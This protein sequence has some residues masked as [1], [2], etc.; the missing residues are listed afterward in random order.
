ML[1]GAAPQDFRPHFR[2]TKALDGSHDPRTNSSSLPGERAEPDPCPR[3][4]PMH[5]HPTHALVAA[6]LLASGCAVHRLPVAVAPPVVVAGSVREVLPNDYLRVS[7]LPAGVTVTSLSRPGA[8]RAFAT[9]TPLYEQPL[10]V[11]DLPAYS[12]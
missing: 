12:G 3:R 2:L 1:R 9:A 7:F 4:L 11:A 10:K 8:L 6:A 5:P